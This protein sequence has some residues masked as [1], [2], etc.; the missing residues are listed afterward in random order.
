MA[1]RPEPKCDA[2]GGLIFRGEQARLMMR[3]PV[4]Q[5]QK[6]KRRRN[7]KCTICNDC[8]RSFLDRQ[9]VWTVEDGM[10]RGEGWRQYLGEAA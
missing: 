5:G 4:D 2:C 1:K 3:D 9:V 7:E 6:Y 8:W 10:T